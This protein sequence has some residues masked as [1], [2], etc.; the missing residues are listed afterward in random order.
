[1]AIQN[2]LGDNTSDLNSLC[3]LL[4]VSVPSRLYLF[5]SGLVYYSCTFGLCSRLSPGFAT[6]IRRFVSCSVH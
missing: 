3:E 5:I 4:R 1:M 2:L 6:S